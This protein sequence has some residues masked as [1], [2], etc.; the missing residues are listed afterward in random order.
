MTP[1]KLSFRPSR[2]KLKKIKEIESRLTEYHYN[3]DL[4]PGSNLK[5]FG[6]LLRTPARVDD[7]QLPVNN[8][9]SY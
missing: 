5:L 8:Y 3:P 2:A 4:D 1:R 7:L 9:R 6:N